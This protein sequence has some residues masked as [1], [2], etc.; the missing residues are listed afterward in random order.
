MEAA[1][2]ARWLLGSA[3]AGGLLLK[4]AVG[5][6]AEAGAPGAGPNA[7][8]QLPAAGA[9]QTDAAP[10]PNISKAALTMAANAGDVLP[11]VYLPPARGAPERRVSGGTRGVDQE[12]AKILVLAPA[13]TGE[14]MA[15]APTLY[16]F[17]S[18]AVRYP[19]EVTVTQDGVAAPLLAATLDQ[20]ARPGIY[21]LSLAD[22]HVALRPGTEYR[23]SVALVVDPRRR[24]KDIVGSG[25]ILCVAPSPA[26]RQQLASAPATSRPAILAGASLWY[27]ALA[28]L[29]DEIAAAPDAK[30]FRTHRAALLDQV[31]LS[32]AAAFDR[33]M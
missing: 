32:E 8:V 1:M 19:V 28:A 9:P 6:G 14:T 30:L 24:A 27:D 12:T 22:A 20:P 23:W 18:Q 13:A 4:A 10:S 2:D 29:S 21:A 17:V 11:P 7:A 31:G 25:G 3:L 33:A 26:L 16:W 5:I 15:T